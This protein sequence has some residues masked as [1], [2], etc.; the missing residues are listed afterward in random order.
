MIK[1]KENKLP[2]EGN[3]FNL[4]K[5]PHKNPKIYNT[6]YG[7]ILKALLLPVFTQGCL[8]L[9]LFFMVSEVLVSAVKQEK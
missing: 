6:V 5:T 2:I 3:G 7:E 9:S 8:L 4:L 1:K